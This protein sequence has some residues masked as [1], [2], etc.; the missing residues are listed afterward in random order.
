MSETKF[1]AYEF[2]NSK[3]TEIAPKVEE[4]LKGLTV[5]EAKELL[6]CIRKHIEET[7]I[8]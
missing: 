1:H 7:K 4:L 8:V 2:L 3:Q 5:S 6:H